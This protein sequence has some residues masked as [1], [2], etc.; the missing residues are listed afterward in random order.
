MPAAIA[1]RSAHP[2]CQALT[3][4]TER[5]RGSAA[6]AAE[7]ASTLATLRAAIEAGQAREQSLAQRLAAAAAHAATHEAA[8][9][10]AERRLSSAERRCDDL[11]KLAQAEKEREAALEDEAAQVSGRAAAAM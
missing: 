4:A 11:G 9:V 3:A 8:L 6:E 10:E 7:A 5:A 2:V 1:E